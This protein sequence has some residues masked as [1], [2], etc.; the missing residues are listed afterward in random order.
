MLERQINK[1]APQLKPTKM[2]DF[3]TSGPALTALLILTILGVMIGSDNIRFIDLAT[4]KLEEKKKTNAVNISLLLAFALRFALLAVAFWALSLTAPL[5]DI[6]IPFF[7]GELSGQS[8]FLIIGGLFL[9]YKGSTEIHEEVEDRGFDVRKITADQSTSFGKSIYQTMIINAVFS[10]DAILLAIG[11]TNGLDKNFMR[12]MVLAA[13]ALTLSLLILIVF[14][15]RLQRI[16]KKH[17]SMHI[18]GLGLLILVGFAMIVEGSYLSHFHLFGTDVEFLPKN[19]IYIAIGCSLIF[20]FMRI[21]FRKENVKG[22]L[23]S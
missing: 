9:L 10:F 18:L 14:K 5:W 22:E 13:I 17:P 23:T 21:K 4:D 15:D 20:L 1:E 11:L 12:V 7:R 2:I 8:L 6:S 16:F 3:L 19:Y